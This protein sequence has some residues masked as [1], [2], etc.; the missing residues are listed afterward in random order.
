MMEKSALT[1]IARQLSVSDIT[2]LIR[3]AMIEHG[4]DVLCQ[5]YA[6]NEGR[7]FA[8]V[9]SSVSQED[10]NYREIIKVIEKFQNKPEF[11]VDYVECKGE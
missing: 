5:E 9:A 6:N 8:V 4:M 2:D 7:K 11:I 10:D 1:Q 3:I